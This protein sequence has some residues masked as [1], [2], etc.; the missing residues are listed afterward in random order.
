MTKTSLENLFYQA[1]GLQFDPY[2]EDYEF[3]SAEELEDNEE[4]YTIGAELCG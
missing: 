2:A 4:S 1:Y 3:Y